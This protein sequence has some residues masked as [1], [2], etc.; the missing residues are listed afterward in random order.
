MVREQKSVGT[1]TYQ[2]IKRD[3][4]FGVLEPGAKLKLEPLKAR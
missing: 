1:S 3:I 2:T 4:I